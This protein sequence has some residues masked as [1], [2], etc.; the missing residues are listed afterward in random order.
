ML[1]LY[2]RG[3][4]EELDAALSPLQR[5][6][7]YLR[8][9]RYIALLAIVMLVASVFAELTIPSLIQ[10]IIDEGIVP[11][12]MAVIFNTTA[13]IIGIALLDAVFAISNTLLSVR[14]AQRF[15]ADIRGAIF[16]KIQSFSFGNLYS[17]Q[18]GQLI[19]R[20]TSDVNT[21]Q[22]MVMTGLRIFI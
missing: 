22:T 19:I 8:P 2:F 11:K 17:F 18:T 21:V 14:T 16:H 6:L 15:A 13:L 7:S 9:Y 1:R 12:D 10:R 3:W 4:K 5:I 20:L